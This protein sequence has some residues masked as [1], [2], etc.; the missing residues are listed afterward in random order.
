MLRYAK[1]VLNIK[2][3]SSLIHHPSYFYKHTRFLKSYYN[4][5]WTL[6]YRSYSD[7]IKDSS[8]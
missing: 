7:L 1:K 2:L 8:V 5:K 4:Q 3:G 6:H